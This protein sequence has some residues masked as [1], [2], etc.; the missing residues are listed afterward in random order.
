MLKAKEEGV[1]TSWP[2]EPETLDEYLE[3]KMYDPMYVPLVEN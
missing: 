2:T 3:R 1:A